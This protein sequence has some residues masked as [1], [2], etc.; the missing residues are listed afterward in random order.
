MRKE[1]LETPGKIKDYT[2]KKI[3]SVQFISAMNHIYM[4]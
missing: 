2:G 4:L 3:K 1:L